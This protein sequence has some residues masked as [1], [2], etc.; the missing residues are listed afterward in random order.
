MRVK[1]L[2]ASRNTSTPE[3]PLEEEAKGRGAGS[4]GAGQ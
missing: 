1:V 4:V 3:A 2:Y